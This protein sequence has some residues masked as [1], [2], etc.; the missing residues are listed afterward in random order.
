MSQPHNNI[1]DYPDHI[2]EVAKRM[3]VRS[4]YVSRVSGAD[5]NQ[6]NLELL[7]ALLEIEGMADSDKKGFK[8]GDSQRDHAN[9]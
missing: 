2:Q 9:V 1:A 3:G 4:L 8:I 7:R 5:E 6:V